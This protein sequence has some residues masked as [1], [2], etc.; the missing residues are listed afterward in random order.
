MKEL[1]NRSSYL[2]Q[3]KEEITQKGDGGTLTSHILAKSEA[4]KLDHEIKYI[5]HQKPEKS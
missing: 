4:A 2:K 5:L 3:L 1:K